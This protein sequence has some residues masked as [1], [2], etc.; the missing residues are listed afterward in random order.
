MNM[1]RL[2]RSITVKSVSGIILLL[3]LF[4]L[5]VS[6]VGHRAVTEALYQQFEEEAFHVAASAAEMIDPDQIDSYFRDGGASASYQQSWTLLDKLCNAS[7]ST[8]IYVIRPDLTDYGS[9]RFVFSTVDH[10]SIYSPYEVGLVKETTNDEYR[11]KYRALYEGKSERE[12]LLLDDNHYE[13]SIH[14]I[15]AMVPLRGSDGQTT[16]ILCVQRQTDAV[17]PIRRGFVRSVMRVLLLLAVLVVV[18]HSLYLNRVF[19]SPVKKITAEATRFAAENCLPGRTLAGEIRS[20]DEIGL[21][22]GEI[23]RME[24]QITRYVENLTHITAEKERIVTELSLARRIQEAMLPHVFPPF[25]E[26]HEFDLYASMD[27]AKEVGGDFYD[28]FLIDPDHLCLLIADVSGKGIPAALFMMICKAILQSCAMLGRSASEILTRTNDGICSNNQTN[29]FV[30][31]WTGIL[32]ISTGKMTAASAGHEYPALK[33]ADGSFELYKD[34][35]GPPVGAM[36]GIRYREYE[37]Q[38][39]PGDSLFVYTDGVPEAIDVQ[40]KAFGT[41]RMLEALNRD[42]AAAP[43]TLLRRVRQE[44]DTFVG[45]AEQFDDITMLG[46]TYHGTD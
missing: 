24:E 28:L 43:E 10:A 15:T 13:R 16:A 26:R 39:Q 30:T 20:R 31:V 19:I 23:D 37:L 40:E 41:Q 14:H 3:V 33:R 4:A 27:P 34:R 21:L 11:E 17:S 7:E 29:M 5:I 25:P 8:F 38:F 22:A 2:G 6:A 35:H 18:V 45:D 12:L 1:K 44:L 9:I 46:F 42:P 32:E 36:E